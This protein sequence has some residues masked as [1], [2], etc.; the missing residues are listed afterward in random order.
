MEI[1]EK[2]IKELKDVLRVDI[3]EAVNELSDQDL[4]DMG[5]FLLTVTATSLKIRA[6]QMNNKNH[7]K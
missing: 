6:R 7:G 3:G 2:A 1:S 4:Q 5:S